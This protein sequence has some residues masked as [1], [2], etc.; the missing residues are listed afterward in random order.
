[1]PAL[2]TE[3]C[4]GTFGSVVGTSCT[5]GLQVKDTVSAT[6]IGDKTGQTVGVTPRSLTASVCFW[7]SAF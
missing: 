3:G 4:A 6:L 7:M 2:S 5:S 1:M